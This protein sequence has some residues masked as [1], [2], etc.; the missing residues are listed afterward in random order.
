MSAALSIGSKKLERPGKK[1][2]TNDQL[3][4]FNIR[5]VCIGVV[6][7]AIG[8]LSQMFRWQVLESDKFQL[9]AQSQYTESQRKSSSRGVI[10]GA[11]GSVLATDEPAWDAYISLSSEEDEREDFFAEKAKFIEEVAS[12]VKV[13]PKELDRKLTSDFRFIPLAKNI[14]GNKKKALESKQIFEQKNSND[15]YKRPPGF[16]LYFEKSEKRIYP[17]NTLAS[18]V[19]GFMGKDENGKDKGLYG[20]EGYYF[21]DLTGTEGYSYEEVDINGNVILTSEYEP[22]LPRSGKDIKLTIVPSIQAKVES[23]LEDGVKHYQAK[24]G[25]AIIM[26]P[27]TGAIIAMANYPDYNPNEYWRVQESWILK[28]KAVGEVYE[29]GSIF[30]PLTIAIGLETATIDEN[31]LCN[32]DDGKTVFYEGT[33]YQQTIYTWDRKPDGVQKPADMLSN[34]N[35][36]CIAQVA[37]DTGVDKYYPLM[38]RF[39]IGQFIGVGLQDEA[40]SYLQPQA[41]MTELDLAVTSFGQSVTTTP[42]QI[43]SALS[44]IAND[45]KRMRPYIVSEV[46]DDDE[47]IK[48]SP[49]LAE[50]VVS[51]ENAKK[52]REM[53]KQVR[54]QGD[55]YQF[56]DR[57]L[58][59]YAIGGKTGTAQIA[60]KSQAGYVA[61]R[62]NA[63]YVGMAPIDN[64]QMI[65]LVKLEEPK[66]DTFA[67]STAIPVWIDIFKDIADDL[68]IP[69][70]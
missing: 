26:N 58:P 35:N 62:T 47:V 68:E 61:N 65:M 70:K 27:K 38:E 32:D 24:S 15:N 66:L 63:T 33:P 67:A 31:F 56:F 36:P 17:D 41:E 40:N 44:T 25:T 42:L 53:L 5:L 18:H 55:G 37:L 22:V 45:G 43:L 29:P 23:K 3:S 60:D 69:K 7:V 34:S 1:A 16:G 52:V 12:I 39:G 21:G 4:D 19:L 20:I 46:I 30:K 8:I 10:Y 51:P 48:Y 57:Y 6:I 59:D 50:K 11:D 28:N 54:A 64:P 2:Y 49:T 13:D 9:L 14:D